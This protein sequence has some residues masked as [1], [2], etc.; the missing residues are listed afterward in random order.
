MIASPAQANRALA[1]TRRQ[2][3]RGFTLVEVLVVLAILVILFALLFMPMM[4]SLDMVTVGQSRVTMQ[5]SVRTAMEQMRRE[6]ANA[7]YVY[8][9]PGLMLKGSDGL[10][11]TADDVRIPNYS[12]VVFVNPQRENGA[13]T[14]PLAPQTDAA[15]NIIA[16]RYRVMKRD[17][18][19][20]YGRANPFVLVREEG[21]YTYHEA[22]EPDPPDAVSAWVSDRVGWIFQNRGGTDNPVRNV[23][24]PHGLFDIPVTRSVCTSCS[25]VTG[26][27]AE[28]CPSCASAEM[29]YI[30]D[31]V[32]F[33]PERIVGEVLQPSANHTLYQA[34][35][36]AW[37]GFH[38][39]GN[40]EL[41]DLTP[42]SAADTPAHL[43]QSPLDP[44]IVLLNPAD[45]MAKVRDSF[46][47]DASN[48]VLTWNSDRGVVQVGATTSRWVDVQDPNNAVA[49]GS[50]YELEVQN[51]RPDYGSGG[52]VDY[53]NSDGLLTQG[54]SPV[55]V[56]ERQWDIVPIYPTLGPTPQPGDP[57]MP[58]GYRIDTAG[59]GM[60]LPKAYSSRVADDDPKAKVVPGSVRVV[61]WGLDSAGRMYQS[62]YSQTTTTDQT[63]IGPEQFAVVL[64]DDGQR[65]EV[66]FNELQPP[67][68]RRMTNAG[69]LV[70]HFGVYVQYLYRRNYDPVHPDSNYIVRADYSTQAVMNL[71]FALQQ[72]IELE[73]DPDNPDAL[74]IPEDATID[75]VSVQDQTQVRNIGR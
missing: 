25:A 38:N 63:Q 42:E 58:I 48:T 22:G 15:G 29:M 45:N 19:Q 54:G 60:T 52:T 57:A 12:E 51:E 13:L 11:G 64:S 44:R 55:A 18:G 36:A 10:L 50:Y 17:P 72:Y 40:I 68:P 3:R 2:G 53:Y 59:T 28:T 6:V 8:P 71:Q 23:L 49:P 35:H 56:T 37:A 39:P 31:G 61:V 7:M 66:L 32:Q 65:A 27:Y 67:S 70:S 24:S 33:R 4:A 9:T 5:T 21:Y 14:E 74:I 73:P 1:L 34:R 20:A 75:R 30:H 41:N 26:G 69:I 47:G 16:T 62:T 43:G 46:E